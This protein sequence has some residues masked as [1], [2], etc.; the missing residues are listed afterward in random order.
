MPA[1]ISD[2][3]WV[4]PTA[5]RGILVPYDEESIPPSARELFSRWR[6]AEYAFLVQKR[7]MARST[8]HRRSDLRAARRDGDSPVSVP[9]PQDKFKKQVEHKERLSK[10]E[11]EGKLKEVPSNELAWYTKEPKSI[12]EARP[13]SLFST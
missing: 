1:N 11:S 12:L 2:D 6:V 8:L 9:P 7:R 5:K 10:A 3:S 13:N 4:P